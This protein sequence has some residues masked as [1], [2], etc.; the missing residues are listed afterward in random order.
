MILLGQSP[1]KIIS[2][3][4]ATAFTLSIVIQLFEVQNSFRPANFFFGP[5]QNLPVG[6]YVALG[7]IMFSGSIT[8]LSR[9][10]KQS[11]FALQTFILIFELFLVPQYVFGGILMRAPEA[12]FSLY[13]LSIYLIQTGHLNFNLFAFFYSNAGAWIFNT[14]QSITLGV[15]PSSPQVFLSTQ[16]VMYEILYFFPLYAMLKEISGNN[17]PWIFAGLWFFYVGNFLSLDNTGDVALGYFFFL[18]VLLL[19]V[20]WTKFRQQKNLT[21]LFL[22][23]I[24]TT[25]FTHTLTSLLV[26]ALI[27][28]LVVI[29]KIRRSTP[30]LFISILIPIGWFAYAAGPWIS[31]YFLSTVSN[32]NPLTIIAQFLSDTNIPR[33]TGSI[34]HQQLYSLELFATLLFLGIGA[35]GIA[36]PILKRQL[37]SMDKV[38]V[39]LILV[40][41]AF[42]VLGVE[43]YHAEILERAFDYTLPFIAYFSA[44]LLVINKKRP[45]FFLVLF[46]VFL[47]LFAPIHLLVSNEGTVSYLSQT[48]IAAYGY[49]YSYDHS[50]YLVGRI[51]DRQSNYVWNVTQIQKIADYTTLS[52]T[53]GKVGVV[54]V[55]NSSCNGVPACPGLPLLA[56]PISQ[57][58]LIIWNGE[59]EE[60][61]WQW[62]APQ[63][64]AN[65]LNDT[66]LLP[67]TTN[68][69]LVYTNG[70]TIFYASDAGQYSITP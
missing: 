30:L 27:L 57:R 34:A 47:F 35:F 37:S 3:V 2:F 36:L 40:T 1:R 70:W 4:S 39:V 45:Q 29:L 53:N 50:G 22:V 13:G 32:I 62:D 58:P 28:S 7:L 8:L 17:S 52:F 63:L 23:I 18:V 38:G 66:A 41:I 31:A 68:V 10:F 12:L 26:A 49:N 20:R 46:V 44:R 67:N 16:P 43:I 51:F 60:Y 33:N 48:S 21:I 5:A 64:L 61:A 24:V 69:N 55:V 25:S 65:Y 11:L 54:N 59:Y 19:I 14:I 56:S 15:S 9:P 42:S 6:Y